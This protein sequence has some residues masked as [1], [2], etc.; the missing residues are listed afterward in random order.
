VAPT[1]NWCRATT[2]TRLTDGEL[3]NVKDVFFCC[4]L[5]NSFTSL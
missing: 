3:Q 1:P 5:F 4:V 2:N